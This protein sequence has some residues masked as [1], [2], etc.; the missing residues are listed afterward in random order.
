MKEGT[1]VAIVIPCRNEEKYIARCLDSVL[2]LDYDKSLLQVLVCDG[3][4][5]DRTQE[6]VKEYEKKYPFIRLLINERQ[7]T[8]FAFNLG[9]KES[10]T[11]LVMSL[12]AHA[13]L[14]P[15]YI[16]NCLSAFSRDEQIGCVGGYAVN[17]MEDEVSEIIASAMSSPFGVG[18]AYFRTGGKE[19]YVDTVGIGTYKREVFDKAGLYDE[20]LTRNQ[21]DEFNFRVAKAGYKIYLDLRLKTKYY[22]RASYRKLFRQYYQYGYWK[23]YV[24]KKHKTVTTAR[25]LV[26]LFFVLFL[27]L[28]LLISLLSVY[29]FAAWLFVLLMYIIG[30]TAA[31]RV[32]KKSSHIPKI[33]YTFFILHWSYGYGYLMG[34]IDFLVLGKRPGQK[35]A[36][37]TR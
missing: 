4:S 32:S 37:L 11:D 12:G 22:V 10:S 14:Y 16:K 21:D 18:N 2:A 27:T 28:G 9:I 5:T 7:T 24:N 25:Q 23:V 17:V 35:A 36:A 30:G 34:I 33:L 8:P 13:E 26:P 19:G 29:L 15:D 31:A 1:T 3:L 20:E 6:I